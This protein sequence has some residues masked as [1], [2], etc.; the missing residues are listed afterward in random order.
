LKKKAFIIYFFV[1]VFF[2][3]MLIKLE[4]ATDTYAVFNFDKEAVYMQY[5]MS[6]RFITGTFLKI[7]KMIKISEHTMYYLS[8]ILAMFGTIF[9]QFVLYL[10]IEKDIKSKL[11]K[12]IIPTLIIIN[13]FSIE[14]FLFIE[15]GFMW[16][17]ILACVLALR[18][19]QRYFKIKDLSQQ[20]KG[21]KRYLL[22][23]LIFMFVANCL[24]QG[25][26]GIFLSIAL[27]Y[28][29]KYSKN[30]KS[31]ITNNVIAGVIYVL[32]ALFNYLVVKIRFKDSRLNGQIIFL[33]SIEKIWYNMINMFK[34]M[35]GMLPKYTFILLILFTFVVFCSKICK[36]KKKLLPI[37]KFLYI[38]I[39]VTAIAITPQI[40]QPTNSIWFV[41]RTMYCFGALYGILILFLAINCNLEIISRI[42]IVITSIVLI[43]FQAQKF[44]N[45]ENDRFLINKKDSIVTMQIIEQINNYEKQSKN[46]ITEISWYQDEKPN[47]TYEGIFATGD[48]NVKSYS[49][50][51][52]TVEILKYYTKKNIMLVKKDEKLSA[53]FKRK[54]W[55]EFDKSQIV[56][57]K[58]RMHLCNY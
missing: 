54:N 38:I 27:V 21:D 30:L 4:Y 8:Y 26:V 19:L 46:T 6:G 17:G 33:K 7:F 39:G 44:I 35:F 25:V 41:P 40:I 1:T 9:S 37:L 31:F 51:W 32:P 12:I 3:G 43:I 10:I 13:P 55:E 15:K 53:D 16:L 56:F 45:I 50:D 34:N 18:N 23:S 52:S 58:N 5:A 48:M 2:F 42:L 11:L 24:Y 49:S 29:L 57:E 47:Y 36:E 14:L 20:S 28:I 22:Y